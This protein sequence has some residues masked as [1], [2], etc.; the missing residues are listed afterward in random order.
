MMANEADICLILEGTYPYV[1]GGVSGWTHDLIRNQPHLKFALVSLLPRDEEEPELKYELPENVISLRHLYLQRLI[2]GSLLNKR[3]KQSLF[4]GLQEALSV[5]TT[6]TA[7]KIDFAKIV[8]LFQPYRRKLG[9]ATLLDSEEA[10]D[11]MSK[12]Y[13][14]DFSQSSFLDYFWS[15]RAVLGGLFSL[16]EFELPKAKLYHA[17]STGYAGLLAARAK[18]ETGRPAVITEHGI[19]TNERRIE[20]ASAE[21]L[22]EGASK[23]LTISQTR[24]DLRDLWTTTFVNYSRIAYQAVDKIITLFADN[25]RAQLADGAPADKLTVI[26]NGIDVERYGQVVKQEKSSPE[27][28][29][30]ERPVVAL[31]GRVVPVKDIKA[32]LRSV[33]ILKTRLGDIFAYVI[34]PTD[35]DRQYAEECRHMVEHLQLQDNVMFTGRADIMQYFPVIDIVAFSSISEAQPLVVLEAGAAGIPIVSTDVGAVREMLYGSLREVPRLGEGGIVVPPANPAALAD[36]MY[37]LLT[38]K[39][40]YAACS[41][42][43][44]QRIQTYYHKRDQHAA[45]RDLYHHHIDRGHL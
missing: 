23:A 31:I 42:A 45:Y 25:Q 30:Q 43:L 29:R 20:I 39:A 26:P 40:R 18:L 10:F 36:G 8:N 1:T 33:A 19:Y 2:S 37:N 27:N 4:D 21:W 7:D 35:E 14:R 16:I 34:G 6:G 15:W 17:V 22:T 24:I 3:E 32:F 28:H 41:A 38:D 13:E 9:Q 5:I 12:M 44:K 11:L